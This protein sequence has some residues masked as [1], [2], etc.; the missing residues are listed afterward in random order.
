MYVW[1]KDKRVCITF[2][3]TN[4][5]VSSLSACWACIGHV[6]VGMCVPLQV[7]GLLR[8]KECIVREWECCEGVG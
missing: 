1:K 4:G 2:L 8:L 7:C 3:G 5:P 6:D